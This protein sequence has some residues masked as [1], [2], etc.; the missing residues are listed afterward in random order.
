[1]ETRCITIEELTTAIQRTNQKYDQ[2]IKAEITEQYYKKD[3]QG[4]KQG[5]PKHKIMLSAKS[6]DKHGAKIN[7]RLNK[8]T[9]GVCWHAWGD[10]LDALGSVVSHEKASVR[11]WR[12]GREKMRYIHPKEHGWLDFERGGEK[13]R[14]HCYCE[15]E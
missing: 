3:Y 11:L 6:G 15:K 10:F 7:P 8:A 2:N 4:Y 14:L 13:P 1:M 5:D 9:G 12:E